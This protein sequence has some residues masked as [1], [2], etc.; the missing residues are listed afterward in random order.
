[1]VNVCFDFSEPCNEFQ[2][3]SKTTTFGRG[4]LQDIA[5]Q[6]SLGR[7]VLQEKL[8]NDRPVYKHAIYERYLYWLN[9]TTEI[10]I[11]RNLNVVLLV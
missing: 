7:Y 3:T 6:L 11:V 4:T 9:T 10:W 8:Y 1:M 2:I 5:V